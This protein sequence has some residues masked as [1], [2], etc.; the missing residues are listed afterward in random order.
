MSQAAAAAVAGPAAASPR[1]IIAVVGDN[2]LDA[3]ALETGTAAGDEQHKQRLAEQVSNLVQ[4]KAA[5]FGAALEPGLAAADKQQLDE[6][7]RNSRFFLYFQGAKFSAE[8]FC[9]SVCLSLA[10]QQQT[11]RRSSS[12]LR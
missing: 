7:V 6:E 3:A 1:K 5:L 11:S 9:L 8:Q 2:C 4:I 10:W 12:W